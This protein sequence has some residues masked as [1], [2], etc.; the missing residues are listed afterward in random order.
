MASKIATDAACIFCKIVKG[1][2]PPHDTDL[3]LLWSGDIPCM[4]LI[5]TETVLAFLDIGPTSKGHSL[6]IPKWH[7]AKL[8]DIPDDHLADILPT[9]KKLVN[10]IGPADYNILQNNG[11]LAHQ[12]VH[13]VHFH[14][15][16]KPNAK[17][18]L[19]IDWPAKPADMEK[20]KEYC[21]EI[22]ARF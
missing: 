11:T 16:P 2:T 12:E 10:A 8:T 21:A 14:M 18:G 4:K 19:I 22:K 15:I 13:H 6:V 7:G 17:E 20:L 5:E 3:H 9:V 1:I